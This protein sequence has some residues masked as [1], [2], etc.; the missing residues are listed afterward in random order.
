MIKQLAEVKEFKDFNLQRESFRAHMIYE[1]VMGEPFKPTNIKHILVY[2]FANVMAV[3][4]E[5][6]VD[7]DEFVDWLDI[8]P[9]MVTDFTD[10]LV[11]ILKRG[12]VKGKETPEEEGTKEEPFHNQ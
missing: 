10:W 3:N 1:E 4:K 9:E 8:H 7:F 2:F 5:L 12:V 11:D 6:A